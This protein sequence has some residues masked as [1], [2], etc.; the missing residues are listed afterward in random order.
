MEKKRTKRLLNL[1][2]A[3]VASVIFIFTE[4]VKVLPP[5]FL[6]VLVALAI[7]GLW[8]NISFVLENRRGGSS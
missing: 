6:L 3:I 7:V 5:I 2:L 8:L 4:I 1:C